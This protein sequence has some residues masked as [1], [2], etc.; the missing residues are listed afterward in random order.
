M[1]APWKDDPLR[2]AS[3]VPPTPLPYVKP[4]IVLFSLLALFLVLIST[5]GIYLLPGNFSKQINPAEPS[6]E[7]VRISPT[8]VIGTVFSEG[9]YSALDLQRKTEADG[10]IQSARLYF[11]EYGSYPVNLEDLLRYQDLPPREDNENNLLRDYSYI[12]TDNNSNCVVKTLFSTGEEYIQ[13][14]RN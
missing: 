9:L 14:C 3:P 13:F 8:P 5:A 4:P 12:L 10:I 11:A 2:P 1:T 6:T 7:K